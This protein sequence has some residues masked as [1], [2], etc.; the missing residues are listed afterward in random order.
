[1]K[2]SFQQRSE[3]FGFSG[4]EPWAMDALTLLFRVP[5]VY[6]PLAEAWD[7]KYPGTLESLERL[8][9]LGFAVRQRGV[10]VDVRS[11]DITASVG[12]N[13]DRFLITRKGRAFLHQAI[14]D[15][16]CV[17]DRWP[18]VDD[19]NTTRVAVLLSAFD[20]RGSHAK[21]GV[22]APQAVLSSGLADRTGRWWVRK[23]ESEG[24]LRR[25]DEK[26]PDSRE[27]IPAHWR[28]TRQLAQQLSDVFGAY[29]R[30]AYLGSV[31]RMGRS[32]YLSD[33]DPA[34]LGVTGA[35]DF[36]HDVTAQHILSAMLGSQRLADGAPFDVEP[37]LALGADQLPNGACAFRD[38]GDTIVLYQPDAILTERLDDGKVRRNIVE[39]ERYQSRK[40]GWAHIERF[41]GYAALYRL[42]FESVA[43]RFVV[44]SDQRIRSY[45]ELIE[46]FCDYLNEH[47]SRAPRNHVVL[48]VSSVPKVLASTDALDERS[49]HRIELPTGEGVCRLHGTEQS[50]FL[51]YFSGR[52]S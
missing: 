28:P 23:L 5:R 44:D 52:S 32:R 46:A 42:P 1:M 49:W 20:V 11:G 8:R 37:R 41:C 13:L 51:T 35:T 27:V 48:C 34:R 9:E 6:Q 15:S 26:L 18:K 39:Y 16:R 30:W 14:E 4:N 24:L 29:P 31:W 25:L 19:A 22:S 43:L 21:F 33:I 17:Q 12:K 40:D 2:R 10:L 47:P 7:K 38:E 45:V 36:D 50:P 3:D